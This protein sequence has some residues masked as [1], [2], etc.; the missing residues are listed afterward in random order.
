MPVPLKEDP[1]EGI[2]MKSRQ[3][4]RRNIL[5]IK[6]GIAF[7]ASVVT[8]SALVGSQAVSATPSST[9]TNSS[10]PTS[11]STDFTGWQD[12]TPRDGWNITHAPDKDRTWRFVETPLGRPPNSDQAFA[13]I[14]GE[15]RAGSWVD[16]SLVSPAVQ[17]TGPGHPVISFAN[18]F[19]P[20]MLTGSVELSLDGAATW[21]TV[22]E[23]T[24]SAAIPTGQVT[25][26]IPQAA[27]HSGVLVRFHSS[28]FASI[29]GSWSI[30]NVFIGTKVTP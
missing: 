30:D 26:P 9:K 27:G 29:Y 5:S 25:V 1:H 7:A 23:G 3:R 15:S 24:P 28:G 16:T 13:G 4:G 21:S 19:T 10:R 14:Y 8:V 2:P 12:S 18:S 17:M 20:Y 22:L 6:A 11:I